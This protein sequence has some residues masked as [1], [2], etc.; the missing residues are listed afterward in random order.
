MA[1]E[2]YR[3]LF[4]RVRD[5]AFRNLSFEQRQ[6][7]NLHLDERIYEEG[8]KADQRPGVPSY[9]GR[10]WKGHELCPLLRHGDPSHS[11][12]GVQ[13]LT[14]RTLRQRTVRFPRRGWI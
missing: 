9:Q 10:G 3:Q 14:A 13:G 1:A 4:Q 11:N 7:T 8:E 5:H 2:D 6:K 12:R